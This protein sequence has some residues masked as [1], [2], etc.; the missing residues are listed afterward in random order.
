MKAIGVRD[1]QIAARVVGR[2]IERTLEKEMDH[3][4]AAREDLVV[5]VHSSPTEPGLE[6]DRCVER[7]GLV[8]VARR[9]DGLGTFNTPVRHSSL[10]LL[11]PV[12]LVL[13]APPI[14]PIL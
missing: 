13:P 10:P 1:P 7:T 11:L 12:L 8:Q 14:L 2:G 5:P 9:Q 3:E 6:A 4:M